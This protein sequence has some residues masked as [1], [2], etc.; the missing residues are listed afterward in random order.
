MSEEESVEDPLPEG[1]AADLK[2]KH[3][4]ILAFVVEGFGPFAFHKPTQAVNDRLVN[5][6]NGSGSE[7]K[8]QAMREFVLSCLCWPVTDAGVPNHNAA[9]ALFEA[10]PGIPQELL[11]E[12]Q[13]LAPSIDIKKL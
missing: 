8:S 6:A 9:R 4:P 1:V 10:S 11:P 7:E 12:I 3:G 13:E 2:S 5:K